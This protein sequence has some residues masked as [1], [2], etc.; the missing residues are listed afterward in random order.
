RQRIVRDESLLTA[1]L[2]TRL[3]GAT[4]RQAAKQLQFARRFLNYLPR[5]AQMFFLRKHVTQANSHHASAAQFRQSK[6][7]ASGSIDS[8]HSRAVQSVEPVGCSWGR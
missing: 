7:S 1:T 2:R 3:R 5:L 8:L 6:V 4:A